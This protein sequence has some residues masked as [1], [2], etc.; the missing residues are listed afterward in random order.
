MAKPLS[1]PGKQEGSAK[2]ESLLCVPLFYAAGRAAHQ[3]TEWS[4]APP[5]SNLPAGYPTKISM[6]SAPHPRSSTTS[7]TGF[8]DISIRSQIVSPNQFG[9]TCFAP[10]AKPTAI[11]CARRYKALKATQQAR[12]ALPSRPGDTAEVSLQVAGALLGEVVTGG[13]L[14]EKFPGFG[15]LLRASRG[16]RDSPEWSKPTI[17]EP[18]ASV[19]GQFIGSEAVPVL[20]A[21]LGEVELVLKVAGG[22]LPLLPRGKGGRRPLTQRAYMIANLATCW[23]SL[24]RTPTSGP[25]SWFTAFCEAV[26]EAIGWPTE[27]VEAAVPDALPILRHHPERITG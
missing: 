8:G 3:S 4:S 23:Q 7:G 13:W 19:R 24:G 20:S 5:N 27:G 15:N 1:L 26:F 22:M 10:I 14:G 21:L 16:D 9:A 12:A 6:R 25:N 18:S 2:P 11:G 17:E